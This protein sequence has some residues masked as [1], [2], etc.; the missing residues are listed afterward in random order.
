MLLQTG[1]TTACVN[2]MQQNVG[3]WEEYPSSP[4]EGIN[5]SGF[6]VYQGDTI[7]ASVYQT[8]T[9]AWV[10]RV[11]DVSTGLSGIMLTGAGWGV[12]S[13]FGT[14]SFS[15]QGSTAS[16]YYSGGYTAEWVVEDFGQNGS[17]VPLA[18]YGTV[19]FSG[20]TTSLPTW[21]LTPTVAM[22]IAQGNVVLSTP[23]PPS[24]DG[25]SVNYTG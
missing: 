3:W 24:A 21:S 4:N 6:P 23:S 10:T 19:S 20:L 7:A 11:D 5:F 18:D 13:D 15:L 17:L 8:N 1:V 9:G 14:G 25:F 16:L 22:E 2:G 12:G